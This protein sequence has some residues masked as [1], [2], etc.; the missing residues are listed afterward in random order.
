MDWIEIK[1]REKARDY[2]PKDKQF[3]AIWKGAP[4]IAEYDDELDIFLICFHPTMFGTTE[5][6]KEREKKFS[7]FCEIELPKELKE[8]LKDASNGT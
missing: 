5:V 8:R 3:F 6:I 1:D 2:L 4:C 7:H